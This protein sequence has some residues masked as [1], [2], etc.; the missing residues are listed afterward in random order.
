MP[1]VG[2]QLTSIGK[3]ETV[4]SGVKNAIAHWIP[5]NGKQALAGEKRFFKAEEDP[6]VLSSKASGPA[7]QD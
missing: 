4:S 7:M 2:D 1:S 3:D 5:S 6:D